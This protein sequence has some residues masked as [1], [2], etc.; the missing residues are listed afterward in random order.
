MTTSTTTPSFGQAVTLTDT[1]PVLGG[2]APTGTVT[3]YNGST[4]IGAG[5]VNASGVATLTTGALPV[6]AN[7]ITAVYGGDTNYG[8]AT[9][10]TVTVTVAKAGGADTLATSNAT[11]MFG[12]AITFTDTIPAVGGTAPT[13]TV[14]FYIGSTSIGAGAVNASGG[15]DVDPPDRCRWG[16]IRLLR[17]TGAIA[18]MAP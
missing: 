13:G 12:Q 4:S 7:S 5:A 11:S 1:L 17:F 2:T 9:S 16:R 8:S 18:T 10:N 15:R 14:T 6:G 3:F